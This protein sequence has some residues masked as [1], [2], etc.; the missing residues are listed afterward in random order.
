METL[1]KDLRYGVRSLLKQ[2]AFTLVA[3]ITLALGIGGNSAMFSVVNAVLLRPLQ[4]PESDRIV[5][6]EGIN[7]PKGITQSNMSIPDFADWQKQ[8]QVFE[9][10]AGFFS[11][12]MLLTSGDETERVRTTGVTPDF[13]PLFRAGAIKGRTLQ[14]DDAQKGRDQVVLLSYAMWQRRFGGDQNVVGSK[15]T[16]SGK[17]TTVI[18][19]MPRGFEYPAQS[20]LWVPYPI[21]AA[22]EQRDNRFFSVVARIA[23]GRRG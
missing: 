6:F 19:V 2:P 23:A 1:F 11:G 5:V 20:E 8:N 10:L 18:G 4:Y 13:F 14:A 3:V 9:Q 21:D 22:A 12:G 15:V 17:S 16:L 7:P